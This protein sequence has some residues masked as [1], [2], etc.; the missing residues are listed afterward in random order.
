MTFAV[1]ALGDTQA[2]QALEVLLRAEWHEDD[3]KAVR[4]RIEPGE[5]FGGSSQVDV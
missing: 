4:L 3:P 5:G 2:E 1:E